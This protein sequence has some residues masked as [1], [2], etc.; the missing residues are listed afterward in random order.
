MSKFKL[1]DT[2][3]FKLPQNLT[4]RWCS[5]TAVK[6]EEYTTKYDIICQ[7]RKFYD[8]EEGYLEEIGSEAT[9]NALSQKM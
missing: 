4:L 9:N 2:V 5:I 8:I 1:L 7:G 6:E 3:N